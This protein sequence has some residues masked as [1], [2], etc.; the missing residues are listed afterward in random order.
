MIRVTKAAMRSAFPE[1]S[2][3]TINDL[4]P[5]ESLDPEKVDSLFLTSDLRHWVLIHAEGEVDLAFRS[6]CKWAAQQ[7]RKLGIPS[8]ANVT[9]EVIQR[10]CSEVSD[11]DIKIVGGPNPIIGNSLQW[12]TR[13]LGGVVAGQLGYG[14]V[15]R[16]LVRRC[17]SVNHGESE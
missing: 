15:L 4:M 2:E 12:A 9:E 8:F 16:D 3:A 1:Y 13:A 10:L 17:V 14:S 5:S 6:H 7:C 11:A